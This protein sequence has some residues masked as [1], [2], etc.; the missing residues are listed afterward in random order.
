M[1]DVEVRAA[2]SSIAQA[3]LALTGMTCAACAARIERGLNALDGVSATVNY[4]AESARVTY[5]AAAVAPR[6]LLAA[7]S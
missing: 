4:A 3:D 7:A 5:D 6:D 2:G 1:A